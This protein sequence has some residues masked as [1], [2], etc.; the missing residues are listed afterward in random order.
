MARLDPRRL[1]AVDMWG[2]AGRSRRRQ[3]IRAEFVLGAIGCSALGIWMVLSTGASFA[4]GAWLIGVG[5]NYIPLALYA[6]DLYRPGRLEAELRNADIGGELRQAA[7]QQLW[8]AVP[9]AVAVTVLARTA[10]QR[11]P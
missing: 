10:S 4:V 3:L 2:T 1:A 5:A 6:H 11:R 8:I 9:F 7:V